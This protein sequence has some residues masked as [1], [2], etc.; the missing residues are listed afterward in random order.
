MEVSSVLK[1][2][3]IKYL[4][5]L[6]VVLLI[7]IFVYPTIYHYDKLEQKYPVR[8]NRLTGK[9]EVLYRDG[10]KDTTKKTK[11]TI[12]NLETNASNNNGVVRLNDLE[13]SKKSNIQKVTKKSGLMPVETTELE[14][15]ENV[16]ISKINFSDWYVTGIL[17]NTGKEKMLFSSLDFETYDKSGNVLPQ[18]PDRGKIKGGLLNPLEPGETIIFSA[19]LHDY[20]KAVGNYKVN[21]SYSIGYK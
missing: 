4:F 14:I 2:E 5:L 21:L 7:A 1:R 9:T 3:A 13:A 8:I 10:W 17:K 15:D 12:A 6:T 19:Y 16:S 18:Q 11:P 20:S